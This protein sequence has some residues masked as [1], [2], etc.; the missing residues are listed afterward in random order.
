MTDSEFILK[1][2]ERFERALKVVGD[3]GVVK[4]KEMLARPEGIYPHP[5]TEG[6][7]P[8]K[9]TGDMQGSAK[10]NVNGLTLTFSVATSYARRLEFGESKF[11]AIPFMRPH[12]MWEAKMFRP[13]LI[14]ALTHD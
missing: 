7:F 14:E 12:R 4:L 1:Q 9:I 2:R 3:A 11:V 10:D 5:R 8:Y 13:A 6:D